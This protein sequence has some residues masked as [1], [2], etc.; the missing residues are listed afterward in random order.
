MSLFDEIQWDLSAP[1]STPMND[2]AVPLISSHLQ[3]KRIA[4]MVCAGIAAMKAP[5]IARALRKRGA[6]VTAFVSAEAHRYVALDALE[7]SCDQEVVHTLSARAEHLGDGRSFDAYLVAPATYNT[8]N[9]IAYGIADT[10]ITS[11]LAS[12]LGRL[13]QQQTKI[14]IAPT[15]HGSMHNPILVESLQRLRNLGVICIPPRDAYGKDNIPNESSLVLHVCK[16]ISSSSLKGKGVLITGGPTP[17]AIDG[18]R[19]LTNKFTGR[20]SIEIAQEFLYRGADVRLLL[21]AGSI[22]PPAILQPYIQRIALLEE[23]IHYCRQYT[24]DSRCQVGI[25]SAAV[26]DY[27]PRQ[28]IDG[29]FASQADEWTIPLKPTLK[30]IQ[31]IRTRC[32][33]LHMLTFK[34]QE[35][36][37]HQELMEIAHKRV[38][39]FGAVIANRG[40]E[41]GPQQEQI[42]WLCRADQA[43][44]KI[45]SKAK[46]A[47][48][49]AEYFESLFL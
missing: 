15:M 19:R 30:V 48:T 49:I 46:I 2:H 24:Q 6:H 41:K 16:A 18:V 29:K 40:E 23:Y 39:Q 33:Q 3:G 44:Q 5:L 7:W 26:A 34:Y 14:L 17:V 20:L 31:D 27:Q 47:T 21:G 13:Q 28:V 4:L 22:T 25:F 12:A 43:P 35:K 1:Q 42:A 32:P 38:E 37:S 9:K 8:I 45:I 36:V 11:T 10:V